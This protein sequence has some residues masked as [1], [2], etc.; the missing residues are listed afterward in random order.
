MNEIEMQTFG[1]LQSTS[2]LNRYKIEFRSIKRCSINLI[3][4]H[5]ST[6]E[7][8]HDIR[9]NIMLEKLIKLYE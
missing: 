9:D 5:V 1:L 2:G 8:K 6:D 3:I 7:L 4:Y